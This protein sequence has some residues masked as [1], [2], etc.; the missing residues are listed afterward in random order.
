MK[1]ILKSHPSAG[2][3]NRI[4]TDV[5]F[6]VALALTSCFFLLFNKWLGEYGTFFVFFLLPW[7]FNTITIK[8]TKSYLT[9]EIILIVVPL[10]SI[11][12][13]GFSYS[14]ALYFPVF[15]GD[16]SLIGPSLIFVIQ[17]VASLMISIYNFHKKGRG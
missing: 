15:M 6:A 2:I 8:L 13:V 5:L 17:I 11:L 7:I 9:W 14:L 12:S 16:F 3:S 1:I 10:A 4:S